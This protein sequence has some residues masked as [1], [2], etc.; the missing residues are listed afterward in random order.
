MQTK[1]PLSVISCL[2][3]IAEQSFEIRE[4]SITR[5]LSTRPSGSFHTAHLPACCITLH[6]LNISLPFQPSGTSLRLTQALIS[7]KTN[8]GATTKLLKCRKKFEENHGNVQPKKQQQVRIVFGDNFTQI[9]PTATAKHLPDRQTPV[10]HS[11]FPLFFN[12]SALFQSLSKYLT[13]LA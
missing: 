8:R 2:C 9:S 5:S 13:T 4:F 12:H 1:L 11:V 10:S 6:F 3:R 7:S